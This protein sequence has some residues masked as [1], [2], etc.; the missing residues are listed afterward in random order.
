MPSIF[1]KILSGEIPSYKIAEDQDHYA[2][3]D[4]RPLQKG[5]TLVIPKMEIDYIFDLDD[6]ALSSLMVF[7]KRVAKAVEASISC[8]RVGVA[9]IGLEVPHVHIH[10]V[11]LQTVGDINF[12]KPPVS[13]NSDEMESIAHKI[14][15]NFQ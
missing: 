14:Q 1:S 11:P 15:S 9:V 12:T 5:H 8:K 10:L 4:I 7:S 6:K 13:V 2:F 3:L